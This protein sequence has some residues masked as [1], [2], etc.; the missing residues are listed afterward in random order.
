M[1]NYESSGG[2][3]D[4]AEKL[5]HWVAETEGGIEYG[6]EMGGKPGLGVWVRRARVKRRNR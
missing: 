2:R 6:L 1:Y 3:G 4:G 5:G